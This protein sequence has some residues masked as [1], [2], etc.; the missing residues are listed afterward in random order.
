L[1]PDISW[2]HPSIDLPGRFPLGNLLHFA[3]FFDDVDPLEAL[4][5]VLEIPI[6]FTGS[7][8]APH[9]KNPLSQSVGH[10]LVT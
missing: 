9:S 1:E 8:K 4:L 5:D 2:N 3:A 10:Q 6:N 7:S